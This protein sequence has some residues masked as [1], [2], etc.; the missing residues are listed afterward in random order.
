MKFLR[1]PLIERT[2][3]RARA[4]PLRAYPRVLSYR[5]Q[6][7]RALQ[8][9]PEAPSEL[10]EDE[11]L[12]FFGTGDFTS[13]LTK[14]RQR[15]EPRFFFRNPIER[16][17]LVE[18][19]IPGLL[20]VLNSRGADILAHRFDLLGSGLTTL[21]N[22]IPWRRDFISG[23]EWPLDHFSRLTMID[24]DAGLDIKVPWELSRFYHAPL[25]GECFALTGDDAY[26]KELMAQL[27]HWWIENPVEFG[28]NWSN[29][30]EVSI[31]AANMIWGVELIKDF[32][33]AD[34]NFTYKYLRSLIEH[35]RY[36]RR[37]LEAGWPGSNHL[38]ADLCG[39]VWLGLYLSPA[40][41]A[42]GWLNLGLRLF[43]REVRDQ[44]HSDGAD[45]E[46]ST[47]YHVLV[48]EMLLWTV[49]YCNQNGVRLPAVMRKR[50]PAMLDVIAGLLRPDGNL[51]LFGD[52]DSG[53]WLAI[54]ADTES[55]SSFQDPRGLLALG[56]VV[57]DRPYWGQLVKDDLRWQAALWA[58]G[59]QAEE[60]FALARE[61]N[62]PRPVQHSAMFAQGGWYVLRNDHDYLA[63]EA[64]V[65]GADGWG[66]HDHNDA[67]S[68]EFA[69]GSRAFLIDPGSY[70]YTGDN[71]AR[72][73]FRS[74]AAHNTVRV[75]SREQNQVP[76]RDL[77]RM[78]NDIQVRT[79][80][81]KIGGSASRLESKCYTATG[82]WRH[83]RNIWYAADDASWFISDR[84]E[85]VSREEENAPF[86]VEWFFHFAPMPIQFDG[87]MVWS[88][89]AE[90]SNVVLRV[91]EHE[92]ESLSGV[93]L[94]GWYSPQY[95]VRLPAPVL[96]LSTT[97]YGTVR[98]LF[99][100]TSIDGPVD[101]SYLRSVTERMV[102][103][104]AH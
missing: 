57:F 25:L 71:R 59:Q 1:R 37:Y 42:Q 30:M 102:K 5:W 14:F 7:R 99:V 86:S 94:S 75:N 90:G 92:P 24:L 32:A 11:V 74:T 9:I 65:V 69:V 54:E 39:L 2:L 49:A 61:R 35:G 68:F 23:H 51:P 19:S 97:G 12:S 84:V 46:A 13:L 88:T 8:E 34:D 60:H 53:R 101:E 36:V 38:M 20:S 48:T 45:Y 17:K 104:P 70:A 18:A 96:K 98:V 81:R 79:I 95:G 47:S 55:L 72:N 16:A 89:N 28:P 67:L 44:I 82:G 91:S 4:V 27:D 78:D 31:R 80:H 26:A 58:Y 41:E 50:V 87:D 52:C 6:R 76:E 93:L 15:D 66:V 73:A 29:A 62:D 22:S 21:G 100:I 3:E 56:A 83:R 63:L 33:F 103:S 64:G 77:F 43:R 85:L 10:A 40:S